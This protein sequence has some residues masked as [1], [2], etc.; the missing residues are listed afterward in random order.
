MAVLIGE[1]TFGHLGQSAL[2]AEAFGI[3]G[4]DAPPVDLAPSARTANSCA[5]TARLVKAC[6]DLSD[7]GL[8]LAAFEMAEARGGLGRHRSALRRSRR[9]SLYRGWRS[10]LLGERSGR[11]TFGGK[12]RLWHPRRRQPAWPRARPCGGLGGGL[13]S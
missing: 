9:L 10:A 13:H 3:E 12:C 5:P 6:T 1:T 2:L 11:A 7:G 8:A 4:G